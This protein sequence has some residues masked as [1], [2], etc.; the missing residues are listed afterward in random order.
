[1]NRA[2]VASQP[3]MASSGVKEVVSKNNRKTNSKSDLDVAG[4]AVRSAYGILIVMQL[5]PL[6]RG[7]G[8]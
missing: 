7:Q 8:S 6:M 1:M 5:V 3:C 4:F 2:T